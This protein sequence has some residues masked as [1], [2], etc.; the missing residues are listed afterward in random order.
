M[1]P[2]T[3]CVGSKSTLLLALLSAPPQP[4]LSQQLALVYLRH[5][6]HQ[7]TSADPLESGPRTAV[8]MHL[9]LLWKLWRPLRPL[10]APGPTCM[11]P[12]IPQLLMPDPFHL[13]DH[14]FVFCLDDLKALNL[15]S[16]QHRCKSF[17]YTAARRD[18][19]FLPKLHGP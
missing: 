8:I 9:D 7:D 16:Q 11:C 3:H 2:F 1:S 13:C 4:R 19:F 15:P 5:C 17:V 6:F 18:L 12:Q 10:S 14:S